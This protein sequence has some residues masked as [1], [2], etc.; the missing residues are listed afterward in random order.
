V[1]HFSRSWRGIH[2]LM[3]VSG[4]PYTASRNVTSRF[5]STRLSSAYDI[6][7]LSKT[8]S[9]RYSKQTACSSTVSSQTILIM[10]GLEK[11]LFN[12]KASLSANLG[13]AQF[14][15]CAQDCD[16]SPLNIACEPLLTSSRAVH[17]KATEPT[18]RQSREGREDREG[19]A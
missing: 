16:S 10:S 9:S 7:N 5:E 17:G 12:L 13:G 4:S 15:A 11:A 6:L 1:Y 2:T 14:A 19:Q 3:V 18:S 8:L